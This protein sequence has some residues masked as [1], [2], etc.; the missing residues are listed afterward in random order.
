MEFNFN[1]ALCVILILFV[2]I[3][4]L[5]GLL[6]T[7]QTKYYHLKDKFDENHDEDNCAWEEE[8]LFWRERFD[9]ILN[10]MFNG[11][12]KKIIHNYLFSQ[13]E[14]VII[15]AINTIGSIRGRAQYIDG[16]NEYKVL[17]SDPDG[18]EVFKWFREDELK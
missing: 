18:V 3:V 13:G 17:Y 12:E 9:K 8:A 14:D 4:F 15:L 2:V 10:F 5:Y 1:T 6:C 16:K 11:E 7:Y